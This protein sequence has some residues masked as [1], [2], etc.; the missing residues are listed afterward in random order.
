MECKRCHKIEFETSFLKTKENNLY[1]ICCSCMKELAAIDETKV[2]QFCK[3][4]DVPYI[5]VLWNTCAEKPIKK[6]PICRYIRMM[7]MAA[8]SSWKFNDSDK[9]NEVYNNAYLGK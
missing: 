2:L 8:Y 6:S 4:F 9:L 5:Q 3:D 1:S 7:Q